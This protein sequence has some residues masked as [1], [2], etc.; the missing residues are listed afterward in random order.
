M[1]YAGWKKISPLVFWLLTF[2]PWGLWLLWKEPTFN[3]VQKL[4]ILFYTFFI[5]TLIFLMISLWS[6]HSVKTLL[7]AANV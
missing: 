5:P 1:N 3:R 6:I 2:P 7:D 4:R